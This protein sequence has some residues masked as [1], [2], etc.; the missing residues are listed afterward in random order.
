[1]GLRSRCDVSEPGDEVWPDADAENVHNLF[2]VGRLYEI[3]G[4]S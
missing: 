2:S 3:A 4:L 1:M